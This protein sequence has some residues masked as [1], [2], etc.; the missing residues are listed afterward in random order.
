MDGANLCLACQ[1]PDGCDEA[2]PL[3]AYR[4]VVRASDVVR[5]ARYRERNRMGKVLAEIRYLSE[6]RVDRAC[7]AVMETM[8]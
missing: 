1:V 6:Q 5:A 2:H 8:G 3:C 7:R 4:Q